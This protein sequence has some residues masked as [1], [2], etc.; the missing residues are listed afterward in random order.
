[1]KELRVTITTH[2]GMPLLGGGVSTAFAFTHLVDDAATD[3]EIE[4][5]GA[6]DNALVEM[7]CKGFASRA[8][9]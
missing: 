2:Q 1:M 6:E 9:L 4:A 8:G 5:L 3:A 7:Y